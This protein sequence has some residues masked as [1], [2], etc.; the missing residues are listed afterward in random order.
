ME[1]LLWGRSRWI[2]DYPFFFNIGYFIGFSFVNFMVTY[3]DFCYT[4]VW[5]GVLGNCLS[6]CRIGV[7]LQTHEYDSA[8]ELY[9]TVHT[10]NTSFFGKKHDVPYKVNLLLE[11]CARH[12]ME[13]EA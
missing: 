13:Y 11:I 10:F 1:A 12:R 4:P 5:F 7:F 2:L 8:N 9:Q 3:V 6:F